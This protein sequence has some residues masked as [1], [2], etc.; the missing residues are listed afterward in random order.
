MNGSTNRRRRRGFTLLEMMLVVVIIGLLATVAVVNLA[1][2]SDKA[3]KGVTKASLNNIKSVLTQFYTET[4]AYPPTLAALVPAHMEKVSKDGW[5][6]D[7]IY[8]P[9]SQDPAHPYTLFSKGPDKIASTA[10]DLSVWTMD[11]AN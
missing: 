1:G 7:F 2:T 6:E 3:R 10:D 5:R 9:S 4:G 8:Y 11:E